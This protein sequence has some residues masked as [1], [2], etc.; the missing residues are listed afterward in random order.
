M[1]R[2]VQGDQELRNPLEISYIAMV[3]HGSSMAHLVRWLT[4]LD[5][6]NMWFSIAER[7]VLVSWGG[8]SSHLQ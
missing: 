5:L 8:Y 6:K 1:I 7:L 4:V 2:D 3:V